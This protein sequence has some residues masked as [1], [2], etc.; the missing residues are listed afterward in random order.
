M[1]GHSC[2]LGDQ[3][4]HCQGNQSTRHVDDILQR[5]TRRPVH[6]PKAG[7]GSTADNSQEA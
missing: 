3:T 2:M 5:S 4:K 1:G 6:S 7:L